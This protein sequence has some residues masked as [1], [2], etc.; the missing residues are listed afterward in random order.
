[1]AYRGV[2]CA[3]LA[4]CVSS[5]CV[6]QSPTAGEPPFEAK[7]LS[8]DLD[9]PVALLPSPDQDGVLYV[10]ER[11][12]TVEALRDGRLAED[13]LLDVSGSVS[14]SQRH[15]LMAVAFHPDFRK[16]R[17]FYAYFVDVQ[18]DAIVAQFKAMPN[19]AA[20]TDSLVATIKF[21]QTFPSQNGG[22]M[23]FGPDGFL[24]V[25]TGNGGERADAASP[26]TLLGKI[27]RIMPNEAGGYSP[28]PSDS[29]QARS[30]ANP[31][32]WASGFF[33]P[34]SLAFSAAPGKLFVLDSR[35]DAGPSVFLVSAGGTPASA[36]KYTA[37]RGAALVGGVV[38]SPCAAS[39]LK[40]HLVL[41]DSASGQVFALRE[42][43]G[44]LERKDVTS[45]TRGKVTAIGL[46]RTGN[47]LAATDR[48]EL[49]EIAE[50]SATASKQ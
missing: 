19:E 30:D 35:G 47:L 37:A 40:G 32:V 10:V 13:P 15:R 46:D 16:N 4:L 39:S 43:A 42:N 27:L 6:A 20:D 34:E 45:V 9:H 1:M 29:T 17:L 49:L 8:D 36:P 23:T 41:A 38:C 18:G 44:T 7:A 31:E 22:G 50:R 48:G 12:G 3:C 25:G 33:S 26:N 2:L 21:A 5:Q 28:G 14:S 11:D 24:Y